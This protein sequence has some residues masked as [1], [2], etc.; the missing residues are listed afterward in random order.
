MYDL[1]WNKYFYSL[2]MSVPQVDQ[3]EEERL[4]E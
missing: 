2:M 4:L 3:R 1:G